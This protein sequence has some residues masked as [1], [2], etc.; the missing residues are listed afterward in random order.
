[1]RTP[2]PTWKRKSISVDTGLN[3]NP[4]S[5]RREFAL[6]TKGGSCASPL[7]KPHRFIPAASCWTFSKINAY[8]DRTV[9]GKGPPAHPFPFSRTTVGY[10]KNS[11]GI[12]H[13]SIDTDTLHGR[14]VCRKD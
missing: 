5:A 7:W 9:A 6:T 8:R 11:I 12:K 13:R 1:M 4:H 3:K 14:P 2:G 10:R